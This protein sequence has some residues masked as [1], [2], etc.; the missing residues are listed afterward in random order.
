M[1]CKT[2][3]TTAKRAIF[4]DTVI[5]ECMAADARSVAVDRE[6]AR[7]P[8]VIVT[9][10]G[11]EGAT[12]RVPVPPQPRNPA[13]GVSPQCS[14]PLG[15]SPQPRAPLVVPPRPQTPARASPRPRTPANVH[16]RPRTPAS[17][18]SR[19]RTPG[20]VHSRPH[21]PAQVP[22]RPPMPARTLSAG[23]HSRPRTNATHSRPP[24]PR[25]LSSSAAGTLSTHPPAHSMRPRCL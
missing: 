4:V 15:V 19:P 21:T 23:V 24:M 2:A 12:G 20:G 16:S 22:S 9:P 6:P 17:V 3:R 7:L 10:T 18:H 1:S 13:A 25:T 5:A 14:T 11:V 8:P